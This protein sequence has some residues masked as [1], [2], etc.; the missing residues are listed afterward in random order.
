MFSR[1]ASTLFMPYRSTAMLCSRCAAIPQLPG[2]ETPAAS[3]PNIL[4]ASSD[5]Q[6][7][8]QT[9]AAGFKAV[10]TP[11]FDRVARKGI[12]LRNAFAASP[13][14]SPWQASLLT[15]RHA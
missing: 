11:A 15:G 13:G 4:I 10:R 2:A 7:C 8:L 9:S 3:R 12:L 6:S 5:D 14:C 1:N